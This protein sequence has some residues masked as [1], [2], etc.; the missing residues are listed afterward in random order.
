MV[1]IDD[2]VI[3]GL[4][5]LGVRVVIVSLHQKI[6]GNGRCPGRLAVGVLSGH[7][8]L[9]DFKT[10][11]SLPGARSAGVACTDLGPSMP[12]SAQRSSATP[13][14]SL[15]SAAS[16]HFGQFVVPAGD[17]HW[18]QL[19]V[20]SAISS[21]GYGISLTG[22]CRHKLVPSGHA[23][24]AARQTRDTPLKCPQSGSVEM[25]DA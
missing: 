7:E 15:V 25:F 20:F 14:A 8:D 23:G 24:T 6:T 1:G 12:D 21:V 16:D 4:H 3:D 5:M 2:A 19:M 9:P 13:L 11:R 10:R 17:S 18:L 22:Q